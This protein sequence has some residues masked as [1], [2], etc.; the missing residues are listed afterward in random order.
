MGMGRGKGEMLHR[1]TFSNYSY[2]NLLLMA[3]Y[4][5]IL[6]LDFAMIKNF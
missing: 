6:T 4:E 1:F 3:G 5:Q 2:K